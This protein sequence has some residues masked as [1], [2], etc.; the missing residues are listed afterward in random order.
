MFLLERQR[1]KIIDF[2]VSKIW[3]TGVQI[4]G[5]YLAN[6][7][8]EEEVAGNPPAQCSSLTVNLRKN[9]YFCLCRRLGKGVSKKL[10]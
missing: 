2:S 6:A 10:V 7:K 4:N 3:Y 8:S 5:V 9:I 1:E